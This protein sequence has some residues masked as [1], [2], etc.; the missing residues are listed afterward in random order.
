MSSRP[1]QKTLQQQPHFIATHTLKVS[2]STQLYLKMKIIKYFTRSRQA[3]IK[4]NYSNAFISI[5][6]NQLLSAVLLPEVTQTILGEEPWVLLRG[7]FEGVPI[8]GFVGFLTFS[9]ISFI[10]PGI[11]DDRH[12][13]A[14]IMFG[15]FS[16]NCDILS[17]QANKP[18]DQEPA[19]SSLTGAHT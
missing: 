1:V 2:K 10:S 7:L 14:T 5:I 17:S 12:R 13:R 3:W 19:V 4:A 18:T 16:R 8:Y 6:Y 11:S 9:N 15:V